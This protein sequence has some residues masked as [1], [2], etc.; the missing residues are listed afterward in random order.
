MRVL[1]TGATGGLGR[2]AVEWLLSEGHEAIAT[3]RNADIGSKLN[4]S[5]IQADLALCP[6]SALAEMVAGCD[7]VWHCA[8]LS[9]PWG[10]RKEFYE[11][12]VLATERLATAASKAGVERFIQISTPA[13]YFDYAHHRNLD[14]N[15][16]AESFANHYAET[17][18]LA[19]KKIETFVKDYPSTCFQII[20]PRGLFGPYDNVI[21]PRMLA[22]LKEN[23]SKLPL[24]GGGKAFLDLTY[25]GNVVHAMYL[26]TVALGVTSGD[27]YNITN[28]EPA[29]LADMLEKLL[30]NQMGMDYS[31]KALPYRLLYAVSALMEG[32]SAVTKKEPR[33]TRYSIGVLYYDM[34]LDNGKAERL[35][36]YKP[37]YSLDEGINLTAKWFKEAGYG[38]NL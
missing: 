38:G 27:V 28:K 33:L 8:A 35:L 23:N 34:T 31:V 7:A 9:S 22:V 26:A 5:F 6:D 12:N 13:V 36:G 17:K 24:P 32:I 30:K 20:R 21:L 15:Y 3:G 19:E 4:T 18:Y 29:R 37:K 25:T 2:N 1:I 14:E 16:L 11:C 10:S